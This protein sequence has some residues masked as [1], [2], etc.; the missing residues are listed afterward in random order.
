MRA[1]EFR[2]LAVTGKTRWRDLPEV[3]T[4]AEEGVAAYRWWTMEELD[5]TT[6]RLAPPDFLVRVREIVGR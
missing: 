4:V 5:A 1:G 3:P 6:E 2:A